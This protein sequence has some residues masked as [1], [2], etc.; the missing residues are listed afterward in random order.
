MMC[1][2]TFEDAG[3]AAVWEAGLAASVACTASCARAGRT[4]TLPATAG[5]FDC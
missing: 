5:R 4:G 2:H 3:A 1:S